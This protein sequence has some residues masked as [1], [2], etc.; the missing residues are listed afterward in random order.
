M[1]NLLMLL[2]LIGMTLAPSFSYAAKSKNEV[3]STTSKKVDK[4][5]NKETEQIRKEITQDAITAINETVNAL[6][7]LDKKK[8]KSALRSLEKATGKLDIILA[9]DPSLALAPVDVVAQTYDTITTPKHVERLRDDAEDFLEDGRVQEARRILENLRSETV[10]STTNIPLA[11]YPQAI[12]KAVALIDKKKI[13]EAKVVLQVA[14]NTLVITDTIIPL[15]V[16]RAKAFLED[17]EKLAEN[18]KRSSDQNKELKQLLDLAGEEIELAKAFGYGTKDELKKF[19]KE[20][21][22]IREKTED[23]KSGFGFF[24]KIKESMKSITKSSQDKK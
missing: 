2:A 15:P 12:K 24:K 18:K 22:E 7:H 16:A 8:T 6:R 21:E 4:K 17:A 20:L 1:K 9:R 19:K 14:L 3:K 11:T 5:S 13:D 10:I 23:G